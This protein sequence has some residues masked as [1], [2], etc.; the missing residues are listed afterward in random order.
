MSSFFGDGGRSEQQAHDFNAKIK[1]RNADVLNIEK[2]WSNIVL[3]IET[4]DFLDDAEKFNA[5]VGAVTRKSG[6]DT[7]GTA[8]DV[9]L[10]SIDE[11]EKQISRMETAQ[12]AESRK[13]DEQIINSRMGAELDQIYGRNARTAAKYRQR[14]QMVGFGFKAA[15]LLMG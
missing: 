3:G 15:S 6:W 10:E 2:D 9:Y 14:S 1:N 4:Q 5:Q 13:Y 7:S 11:Q 12:I 8:L